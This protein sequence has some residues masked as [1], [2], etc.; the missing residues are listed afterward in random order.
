MSN[1]IEK[2]RL[3]NGISRG[4]LAA[5]AGWRY[6][7]LSNYERSDRTP[8]IDDGKELCRAFASLGVAVTLDDLFPLSDEVEP[9]PATDQPP[10]A[11][12]QG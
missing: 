7:R 5:A 1:K 6:S 11:E 10:L 9:A 12:A 3:A 4:A 2:T 8:N